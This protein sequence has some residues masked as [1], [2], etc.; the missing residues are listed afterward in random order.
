[1]PQLKGISMGGVV[2]ERVRREALPGRLKLLT[3]V[4]GRKE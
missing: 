1:L 3:P 4:A 2:D